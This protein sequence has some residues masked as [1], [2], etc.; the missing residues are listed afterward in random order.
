M[1]YVA[2]LHFS[3]RPSAANASL[4][5]TQSSSLT[6]LQIEFDFTDQSTGADVVR[7]VIAF[8]QSKYVLEA[9][10]RLLELRFVP[11][12]DGRAQ[13][14]DSSVV[15]SRQARLLSVPEVL[16]TTREIAK[17]SAAASP[18]ED[19]GLLH[20]AL[21]PVG[22]IG[23]TE[24]AKTAKPVSSTENSAVT[25]DPSLPKST[26]ADRQVSQPQP[27]SQSPR[28]RRRNTILTTQP[29][30]T[31]TAAPFA[32]LCDQLVQHEIEQMR[33]IRSALH[34]R[35]HWFRQIDP[36]PDRSHWMTLCEEECKLLTSF[37]ESCRSGNVEAARKEG[38]AMLDDLKG[39]Q[40]ECEAL[41]RKV[42]TSSLE[43]QEALQLKLEGLKKAMEDARRE[44]DAL[45]AR[46]QRGHISSVMGQK[47][48]ALTRPLHST[49]C[50]DDDDAVSP[51]HRQAEQATDRSSL[52]DDMSPSPPSADGI[53]DSSASYFR[54]HYT[55]SSHPVNGGPSQPALDHVNNVSQPK[56]SSQQ[57][58]VRREAYRTRI[59]AVLTLYQPQ[60]LPLLDSVL[61]LYEG[62][63]ND[64]L[65]A[66]VAKY[67]PEPNQ[68]E[69]PAS[70]SFVQQREEDSLPQANR[71]TLDS[72]S[73]DREQA[74][75][76]LPLFL[77]NELRLALN[78]TI[79]SNHEVTVIREESLLPQRSFSSPS[80]ASSATALSAAAALPASVQL[81]ARDLNSF[82]RSLDGGVDGA[83]RVDL[84]KKITAAREELLKLQ[85]QQRSPATADERGQLPSSR[86]LDEE[87]AEQ[88]RRA[89]PFFER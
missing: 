70:L 17:K 85:A 80:G 27:V 50:D 88:V 89:V 41:V 38:K 43:R 16:Q 76:S 53:I 23:V 68:T 46:L 32:D 40:V 25:S 33:S 11:K 75:T 63:E 62:R 67:G 58:A 3:V 19:A 39:L 5:S 64:L 37:V 55:V 44:E 52:I 22:T 8:L 84:L 86:P 4:D 10:D 47:Q 34:E 2:K 54:P 48:A 15:I 77:Q 24:I 20:F 87:L 51:I 21:V 45:V 65:T 42:D 59:A 82:L 12:G 61:A 66:Y 30:A 7:N 1:V 79:A 60:K 28:S 26:S 9:P 71:T 31:A 72:T 73:A 6:R 35:H 78:R 74:V 56:A 18:L 81:L 83:V 36:K 49:G 13:S 57:S 69:L 29:A 14:K